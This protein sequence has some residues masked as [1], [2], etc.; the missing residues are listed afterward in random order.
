MN[1]SPNPRF[2]A[3]ALAFAGL[4]LATAAAAAGDAAARSRPAAPPAQVV[5]L[6]LA[7]AE[8]VARSAVAPLGVGNS[9]RILR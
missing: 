4:V 7:D 8:G 3:V 1:S 6:E 2:A 9:R 5:K